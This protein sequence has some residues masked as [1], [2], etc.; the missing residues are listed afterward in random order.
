MNEYLGCGQKILR[1]SG[2]SA[3]TKKAAGIAG[4]LDPNRWR[5]DR[6]TDWAFYLVS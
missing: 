3:E 4:G 2:N 1:W 5:D 6:F